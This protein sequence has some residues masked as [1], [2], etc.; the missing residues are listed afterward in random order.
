MQLRSRWKAILRDKSI[1]KIFKIINLLLNGL[2]SSIFNTMATIEKFSL[3]ILMMKVF[4]N[5]ILSK[6]TK[7][8][9]FLVI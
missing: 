7:T 9:C 4:I 3:K 5:L 8:V 6:N 1:W 2:R